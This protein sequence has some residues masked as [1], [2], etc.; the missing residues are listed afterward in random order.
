M[1]GLGRDPVYR[2]PDAAGLAVDRPNNQ[3]TAQG[4][5]EEGKMPR[6]T[7]I[8]PRLGIDREKSKSVVRGMG[9]EGQG[10]RLSS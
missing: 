9:P 2:S 3:G 6:S 8:G 4:R 10:E 7:A 5:V 1:G